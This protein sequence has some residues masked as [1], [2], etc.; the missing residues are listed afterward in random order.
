MGLYLKGASAASAE[1]S[2]QDF[3]KFFCG[4]MDGSPESRFFYKKELWP[5]RSP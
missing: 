2:A 1:T 3:Y 5:D 4:L